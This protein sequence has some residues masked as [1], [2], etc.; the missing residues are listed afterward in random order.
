MVSSSAVETPG[1]T[2]G[3]G[4]GGEFLEE[5][6]WARTVCKNRVQQTRRKKRIMGNVLKHSAI[7]CQYANFGVLTA[8][9]VF[10]FQV[11]KTSFPVICL[12]F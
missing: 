4:G 3:A 1:E 10:Y 2:A 6:F 8:G 12:S 9:R 11:F 7:L 5:L